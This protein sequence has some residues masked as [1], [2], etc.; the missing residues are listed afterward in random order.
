MAWN[1]SGDIDHAGHLDAAHGPGL[2]GASDFSGD[3][4]G[5]TGRK[6]AENAYK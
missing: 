3:F 2:S 6:L 5:K 1:R 4:S